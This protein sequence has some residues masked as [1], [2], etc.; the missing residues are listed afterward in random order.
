MAKSKGGA[1]KAR[2]G[3]KM[4]RKA[5]GMNSRKNNAGLQSAH[6]AVSRKY[7]GKTKIS[8]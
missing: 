4:T 8:K 1:A 6:A 7:G 5:G 2:R 3:T